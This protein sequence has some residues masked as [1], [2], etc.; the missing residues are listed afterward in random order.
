MCFLRKASLIKLWALMKMGAIVTPHIAVNAAISGSIDILKFLKEIANIPINN[1]AIDAA[2]HYGYRE[3]VEYLASIGCRPTENTMALASE[4]CHKDIILLLRFKLK[5]PFDANVCAAAAVSGNLEHLKWLRKM[6]FPWSGDTVKFAVQYGRFELLKWAIENGCPWNEWVCPMA[7]EQGRLDI[8]EWVRSKGCPWDSRTCSCAAYSNRLGV[9][10]WAH[11]NGCPFDARE[12]YIQAITGNQLEM[13]RYL[14]DEGHLPEDVQLCSRAA[15]LGR[16]DILKWLRGKNC[17][18]DVSVSVQS[19]ERKHYELFKWAIEN[20]C[21]WAEQAG[22]WFVE[23]ESMEMLK[24]LKQINIKIGTLACANAAYKNNMK[25]LKWLRG[26][27]C[28][29]DIGT[30]FYCV[31]NNNLDMLKWAV[32]NDCPFDSG[33][34]LHLAIRHEHKDIIEWLR[35]EKK[36]TLPKKKNKQLVFGDPLATFKE[37]RVR[38]NEDFANNACS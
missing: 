12:A 8:L 26:N 25:L 15:R 14:F 38:N 20:G 37:L 17:P 27:G 3:I 29:W 24:W 33:L 23:D 9:L 19:A 35:K 2:A 32:A 28:P 11:A 13:M 7:A 18:W 6:N 22:L 4:G 31:G 21:P 5:C 34:C 36:V 30:C 10:K 16:L 1:S